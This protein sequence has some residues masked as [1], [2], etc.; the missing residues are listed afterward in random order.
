MFN[1]KDF[2][3]YAVDDTG[4]NYG[5]ESGFGG[6]GIGASIFHS[7]GGGGGFSGGGA[8][9][10]YNKST[11]SGDADGR[12]GGGGGGSFNSGLDQVYLG[13]NPGSG[14]VVVTLVTEVEKSGQVTFTK[15]TIS[16]NL[17]SAL[18]VHAADLDNDGDQDILGVSNNENK[19]V[20]YEQYGSENFTAN[21]LS[22]GLNSPRQVHATD[23]DGDGDN[24]VVVGLLTGSVEVARGLV[25]FEND[26]R[27]E[28]V[29]REI[30]TALKD[31]KHIWSADMDNDFRMDLV[32]IGTEIIEVYDQ[33]YG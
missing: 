21:V 1:S 18:G 25:W 32:V 31:I 20:W 24:D 2:T 15:H 5:I 16:S 8:G 3:G 7:A 28:F 11:G 26:G 6:G 17:N 13:F 4:N 22:S 10:F 14:K 12:N 9:D 27:G 29:E 19:V 30:N 33:V 23:L